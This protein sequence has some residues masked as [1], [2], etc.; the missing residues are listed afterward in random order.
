MS[1]ILPKILSLISI[2]VIN[3]ISELVFY[4][5]TRDNL[6]LWDSPIEIFE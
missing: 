6:K 1:Q 4:E 3:M 2:Q 5:H